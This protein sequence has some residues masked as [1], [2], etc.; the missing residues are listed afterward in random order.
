MH[1]TSTNV[2][3]RPFELFSSSRITDDLCEQ[4]T[5]SQHAIDTTVD[6]TTPQVHNM[7][8]DIRESS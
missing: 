6:V 8:I 1:E 5:N 2:S 7:E 4:K 3:R